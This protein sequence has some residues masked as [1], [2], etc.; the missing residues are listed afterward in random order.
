MTFL[1]ESVVEIGICYSDV[2]LLVV[3]SRVWASPNILICRW[4]ISHVQGSHKFPRYYPKMSFQIG[5]ESHKI[6]LYKHSMIFV[7][8]EWT[9]ISE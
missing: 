8:I 1:K 6:P 7:S 3:F 2:S 9:Y 4:R 5:L